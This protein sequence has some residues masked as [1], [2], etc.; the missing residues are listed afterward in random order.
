VGKELAEWQTD[1]N[2]RESIESE[3]NFSKWASDLYITEDSKEVRWHISQGKWKLSDTKQN[4]TK[5]CIQ[6]DYQ[7]PGNVYNW[8]KISPI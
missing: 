3:C 2:T 7:E 8:H 1:T 5:K 6:K 4:K